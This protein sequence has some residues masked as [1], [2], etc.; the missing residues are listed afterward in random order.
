MQ[1]WYLHNSGLLTILTKSASWGTR[2]EAGRQKGEHTTDSESN[3][4][5]ERNLQVFHEVRRPYTE[6]T[7]WATAAAVVYV[8][9]SLI[10]MVHGTQLSRNAEQV[11]PREMY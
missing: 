11:H 3:R 10:L 2:R 1:N 4:A 7:W 5:A 8:P 6:V 9:Q